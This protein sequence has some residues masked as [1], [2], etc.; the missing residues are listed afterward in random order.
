[1]GPVIRKQRTGS[2]LI[3]GGD[4]LRLGYRGGV[5]RQSSAVRLA[6][7]LKADHVLPQMVKPRCGL[8]GAGRHKMASV[9]DLR[10][11]CKLEGRPLYMEAP[12]VRKG[13]SSTKERADSGEP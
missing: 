8:V 5:K 12:V 13:K 4:R 7:R 6:L 10:L 9:D 3:T 11:L 1:M 2:K